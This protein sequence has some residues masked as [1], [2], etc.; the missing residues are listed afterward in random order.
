MAIKK[1]DYFGKSFNISYEIVNNEKLNT[2]IF[3]HGWGSN[4]KL[5]KQAFGNYL[6]GF[7][8]V[9]IDMPGFGKSDNNYILTTADYANIIDIFIQ[10]LNLD[11]GIV[12][13][14]SFG[15]KVATLLDPNNLILLS[16]AGIIEEKPFKIRCKIAMTKSFRKLGL[17]QLTKIFRSDDV[18]SMS[19]NMYNTFK[20]V[21]DENF[22]ETFKY[23][24]NNAIIFWGKEDSAVS[25]SSGELIAKLIPKSYFK[26]YTG[27][28]YFF[29]NHAKDICDIMEEKLNLE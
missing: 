11:K 24:K 9:Y 4:K 13:G 14:H 19:E 8:Q 6:K 23:F 25:L 7:K 27:D 16:S 12:L 22:I 5:M 2:I 28:H 3:L 18:S 17:V 20:N 26:S 15:G 29:L 21:V 10:R 1:I